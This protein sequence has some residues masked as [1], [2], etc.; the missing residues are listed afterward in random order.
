MRL[1]AH[2][3]K[4]PPVHNA[5]AEWMLHSILRGLVWRGHEAVVLRPSRA[6]PETTFEGITLLADP[7]MRRRAWADADVAITH[8]DLTR[9]CIRMRRETGVPL[10]H[11]V[12]NERQM[13]FHRVRP[14]ETDLVVYNSWWIA[15]RYEGWAAPS[16]VVPPPVFAEDY[17]TERTGEAI[18]LVNL[19]EAKGAP[20][21]WKLAEAMP[22]RRFIAVLGAYAE[23]VVPDLLPAN[24]ELVTNTPDMRSVYARTR[25]V[26]MPSSYESWGRVAIEAA[27]SGIPTI[28][29]PTPGLVESL[30]FAGIFADREDVAAWVQAIEDLDH[31]SRY[32]EASDAARARATEL[33]P[34]ADLDLLETA[35]LDLAERP[36]RRRAAGKG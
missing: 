17:R 26:L 31:P 19:S 28:A 27:A 33:D 22:G 20:L 24:V 8:L 13:S 23:Q 35:L 34:T 5:G 2:V 18:T 25:V 3:H 7:R 15:Q 10:V 16:L 14:Q 36:R 9:L 29:H 1:V 11:L 32:G 21:F 4:Y 6:E 12:H 30:D